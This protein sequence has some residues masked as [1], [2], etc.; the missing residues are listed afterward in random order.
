MNDSPKL[1]DPIPLR[2]DKPRTR[3]RMLLAFLG[4]LLRAVLI[5]GGFVVVYVSFTLSVWGFKGGARG[6]EVALAFIL[7]G[8][9]V[10]WF[11]ERRLH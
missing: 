10:A 9:I 1:S 11:R 3:K 6:L 5:V 8:L 7:V 4:R 2:W